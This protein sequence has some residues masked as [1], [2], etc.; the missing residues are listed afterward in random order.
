MVV[1]VAYGA[2]GLPT[3][4]TINLTPQQMAEHIAWFVRRIEQA[5]REGPGPQR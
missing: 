4:D 2:L 5:P 3:I 1:Y